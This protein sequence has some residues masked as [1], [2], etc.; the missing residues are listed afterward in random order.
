MERLRALIREIL[1]VELDSKVEKLRRSPAYA[2]IENFVQQKL[3]EEEESYDFIELQ[4]LARNVAS[5]SLGYD[6]DDAPQ[7]YV[8][9]VK[10]ELSSYGL[11]F[12]PRQAEK[13]VRGVMSNPHG[14]HPFAGMSGGTGT[15]MGGH[16]GLGTGP[17][18]MG[19]REEWRASDKRSLP[20]G[21]KHR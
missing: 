21:S 7:M 11:T 16:I 8:K 6:V 10:N 13:R 1:E 2:S 19:G 20:M 5:G 4:A 14:R 9:S 18:A 17:G 12:N 3:D 15:M